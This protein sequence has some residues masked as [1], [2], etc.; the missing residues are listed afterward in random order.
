MLDCVNAWVNILKQSSNQTIKQYYTV[1]HVKSPEGQGYVK[2]S[3]CFIS[4][5]GLTDYRQGWAER[6]PCIGW[7]VS[8]NPAG[9]AENQHVLI[10][11]PCGVGYT[12]F[13][14]NRGFQPLPVF[15]V[16]CRDFCDT[17]ISPVA[18]CVMRQPSPLERG[19][20]CGEYF[21]NVW[22]CQCLSQYT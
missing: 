11:N 21:L 4:P 10:C 12:G 2:N 3:V 20:V 19:R 1:I 14:L 7:T 17:P 13:F 6:H 8:R 15:C 18:A 16:P 5:S 22:L 9:V